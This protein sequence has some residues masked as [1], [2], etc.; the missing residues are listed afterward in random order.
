MTPDSRPHREKTAELTDAA[1]FFSLHL[2]LSI[3]KAYLQELNATRH[4]L[5][6]DQSS[7]GSVVLKENDLLRGS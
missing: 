2:L 7:N 3:L 5:H 4:A 1:V 6:P